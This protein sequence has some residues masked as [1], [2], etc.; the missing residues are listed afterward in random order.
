MSNAAIATPTLGAIRLEQASLGNPSEAFLSAWKEFEQ[1]SAPDNVAQDPDWVRGYFLEDLNNI[2]SY[3]IYD[4]GGS[5]CG[6]ASFLLKD[7]PM[8]LHLGEVTLAELPLRRLR[9]L[10]GSPSLPE[11]EDIYD[12]VFR[13]LADNKAYDAVH[14][15]Q[16]P[17]DSFLWRYIAK[18]ALVRRAFYCYQPEPPSIHPRLRFCES[19]EEYMKSNFSKTHRHTLRRK[20][21][22]FQEESPGP[23]KLVRYTS[24]EEVAPFLDAAVQVSK[25]TYQWNLHQRGLRAIQRFERRY[26]FAAER[27]WFR[28]YLL[29]CGDVPC[30]FLGGYQW[31]GRYYTDEI[32]FDPAFTKHSPGTVLQMLAIQD[33]FA[34]NRPEL[35]DFGSYDRY[36]EEFANDN[37]NHGDL[38][39]FRRRAYCRFIQAAHY[40]CRIT[41]K[42][43][44]H[45]LRAL[46]LKGRLKRKVRDRSV[47][48][49]QPGAADVR[50]KT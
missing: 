3:L 2:T 7:W 24:S 8:K 16:V 6:S 13:N 4:G 29:F 37:Y 22:R 20:V 19:F 32:G 11:S 12:L 47:S 35:I 40:A 30:A 26:G 41:T 49:E 28:S 34:F 42:A 44:V 43:A 10:G 38:L 31:K 46:N 23:V 36:K 39:L 17:L 21:T 48:A 18:S 27:G 33:M 50:S 1:K 15:A 5:V 45:T 9:L 14:L 25:K